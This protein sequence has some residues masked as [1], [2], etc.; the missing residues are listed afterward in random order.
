MQTD[1][2]GS[3]K[4]R[5]LAS[6]RKPRP[7]DGS[8]PVITETQASLGADDDD[9]DFLGLLL[10]WGANIN[11]LPTFVRAVTQLLT[12]EKALNG[13]QNERDFLEDPSTMLEHK[14]RP[15]ISAAICEA[16]RLRSRPNI[17]RVVSEN[18][19]LA[20]NNHNVELETGEWM[21]LSPRLY[22][23]YESRRAHGPRK[24]QTFR[25]VC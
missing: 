21:W 22:L 3:P 1:E 24:I 20:S 9:G 2:A 17:D 8:A 18:T 15:L 10:L 6:I 16:L 19:T 25:K 5:I 12:D 23:H 7:R 14:Y 4:A 11:V 13:L